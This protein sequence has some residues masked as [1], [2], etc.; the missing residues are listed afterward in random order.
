M[1]PDAA[2]Q[3]H[4]QHLFNLKFALVLLATNL[5]SRSCFRNMNYL[6]AILTTVF[7][8]KLWQLLVLAFVVT[9]VKCFPLAWHVSHRSV[10]EV[11]EARHFADLLS[12][13]EVRLARA[14]FR[15]TSPI[16]VTPLRSRLSFFQP[17]HRDLPLS[18]S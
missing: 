7:P 6:H 4:K 17:R 18:H 13:T 12:V 10:S 8:A 1:G 3:V 9:N 5:T 16:I 11:L 14:F 2:E 15:P